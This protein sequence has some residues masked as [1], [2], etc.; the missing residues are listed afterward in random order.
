MEAG[1]RES[2]AR[3]VRTA[4]TAAGLANVVR[5]SRLVSAESVVYSDGDFAVARQSGGRG[6]LRT[7]SFSARPAAI[8]S[9]DT[10]PLSIHHCSRA[11]T[12][13]RLVE[14]RGNRR[15]L[16]K[17]FSRRRPVAGYLT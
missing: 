8:R 2:R 14:T 12:D 9:R 6:A 13:R 4:S 5:R 16:A 15:I 10:L 11:S 1:R 7:K 17:R 3:L